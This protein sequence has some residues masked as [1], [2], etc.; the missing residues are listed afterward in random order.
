MTASTFWVGGIN[1]SFVL[2]SVINRQHLPA[3]HYDV[4]LL[5]PSATH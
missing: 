4:S 2:L 1:C 5:W 3:E